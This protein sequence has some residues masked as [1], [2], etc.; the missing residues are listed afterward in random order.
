MISRND[1]KFIIGIPFT[2]IYAKKI[3]NIAVPTI[4][5]ADNYIKTSS[6]K[7]LY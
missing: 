7:K 2:A 4:N 3:V 1:L 6:K 5:N